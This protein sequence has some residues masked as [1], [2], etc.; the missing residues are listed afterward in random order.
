MNAVEQAATTRLAAERLVV[1]VNRAFELAQSTA[2]DY[3]RSA[4]GSLHR[5]RA[6]AW[7]NCLAPQFQEIYPDAEVFWR[8]N[9][10]HWSQWKRAELLYD[11]L[12]CRVNTVAT[13]RPAITFPYVAEA[14]WQVESEVRRRGRDALIDF[15]KLVLGAAPQKLFVAPY[16]GPLEQER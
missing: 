16:V 11:I 6:N 10:T 1:A 15:S 9:M 2:A 5:R 4:D 12:V 13:R 8:G 14:I 3:E 7:I